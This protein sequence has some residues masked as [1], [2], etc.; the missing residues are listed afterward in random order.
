[1]SRIIAGLAGKGE[2]IIDHAYHLDRA[3]ERIE[4]K[5]C[6]VNLDHPPSSAPRNQVGNSSLVSKAGSVAVRE[7][8][9]I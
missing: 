1:L 7:G 2:A 6:R 8:P 5:R 3:L 9:V 4:E